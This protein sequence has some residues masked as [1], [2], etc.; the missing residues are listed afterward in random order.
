MQKK[1]TQA[2]TSL[3]RMTEHLLYQSISDNETA[4]FTLWG[5]DTG[6]QRESVCAPK[7]STHL[8]Y[9]F[10]YKPKRVT[11]W[12]TTFYN[13]HNITLSFLRSFLWTLPAHSLFE[14]EKRSISSCLKGWK[15]TQNMDGSRVVSRQVTNNNNDDNFDNGYWWYSSVCVFIFPS[16]FHA[17]TLVILNAKYCS[18]GDRSFD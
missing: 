2:K 5:N 4:R 10:Y 13:N 18:L 1:G 11:T 8:S 15:E 12:S 7:I 3:S 16:N 17:S 9:L 6:L 14:Y